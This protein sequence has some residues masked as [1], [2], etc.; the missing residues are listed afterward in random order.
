MSDKVTVDIAEDVTD[1]S[2]TEIPTS[3]TISDPTNT[4]TVEETTTTVNIAPV[5][6]TVTA[7]EQVTTVDISENLTTVGIGDASITASNL[8][9]TIQTSHDSGSWV[10]GASVQASFDNLAT[11]AD[12][13]YVNVTGDTMTGNL[14]FGDY[15]RARF[16]EGND[17]QIYHNG[18]NSLIEET[19]TGELYVR[20]SDFL[21][22]Q[23]ADNESMAK[24]NANG[25]VDL[26]FNNQNKFSTT[27]D[28]IDVTGLVTAKVGSYGTKLSYSNSNQSGILDTYGNH[29]LEFRANNDRAMNIAANGDISF[30]EDT[31][32]TPKLF[33]DASAERLGIGISDPVHTL[34][35][36]GTQRI[37]GQLMVGD[38]LDDNSI[39]SNAALHIKN[40]GLGARIRIEDKD[41]NPNSYWD[42]LVDR[43]DSFAIYEGTHERLTFKEGGNLGIGTTD[44]TEKLDVSG[45]VKATQFKGELL[46]TINTATTAATQAATDNSTKV[47]TT[48]YVKTAV[49]NLVDGSP[50]ALDTLNEL[51]SALGDDASFSTTV[52]DSIG[53]KLAKA[54][55]LSDLADAGTARTN[56][57]LGTAA[58]IDFD[59]EYASLNNKPT[60][61]S[62]SAVDTHLNQ[63]T[64]NNNEVLSWTGTDYDWVP[65]SGGISLTSI[66]VNGT[67]ATAAGDGGIAYNNSSGVFQYTPPTAA[68]IGA[69]TSVSAE[70]TRRPTSNPVFNVNSISYNAGTGV[71][72]IQTANAHGFGIDDHIRIFDTSGDMTEGDYGPIVVQHFNVMTVTANMGV[73]SDVSTVSYQRLDNTDP[74]L[75][76]S[77]S[78]GNATTVEFAGGSSTSIERTTNNKITFVNHYDDDSVD[79]YLSRDPDTLTSSTY[80]KDLLW[81]S[82]SDVQLNNVTYATSAKYT[83]QGILTQ[84]KQSG[85]SYGTGQP[86]SVNGV[87][88]S[89][90]TPHISKTGGLDIKAGG[91]ISLEADSSSGTIRLKPGTS[92]LRVERSTTALEGSTQSLAFHTTDNGIHVGNDRRG[93]YTAGDLQSNADLDY[94][95]LVGSN[96]SN[97]GSNNFGFGYNHT[98]GT[99]TTQNFAVGSVHKITYSSSDNNFMAGADNRLTSAGDMNFCGGNF[100]ETR[101]NRNFTWAEGIYDSN[102]TVYRAKN[103]GRTNCV[104]FGRQT[105]INNLSDYCMVG[106]SIEPANDYTPTKISNGYCSILWGE[107]NTAS[108]SSNDII[109]GSGTITNRTLD[110]AIFGENHLIN[111]ESSSNVLNGLTVGGQAITVKGTSDQCT[112]FGWT[113][114][115]EGAYTGA[116]GGLNNP[117]GIGAMCFGYNLK[118]PLFE[119]VGGGDYVWDNYSTVVG[120]FND[121][122]HKYITAS[123][124]STWVEDHRFVVGTGVSQASKANGFIVALPTDDFSGIIMPAL[125]A[126]NSH[127]NGADAK[128]D[129]VPVGGLYHTNGV[130]KVVLTGD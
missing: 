8:A 97:L 23:S 86:F 69:L 102:G 30:Y 98:F 7:T 115:M 128:A 113:H 75:K 39:A 90:L 99:G 54:S 110:S 95:M 35:V 37:N 91:D 55:N 108:F 15:D 42:M 18:S 76:V 92:G 78:Q 118:T 10:T 14:N 85:Q 50:A 26:Q 114:T 87:E 96:S 46:G 79:S 81:L 100:T 40:S 83:G 66:S 106:G 31:G 21:W 77:D 11:T 73:P 125:A 104:L 34:H 17:L 124:N 71:T 49:S 45:N 22:I 120:A 121:E 27:N 32:T 127:A 93:T 82:G 62:D 48:A 123:N 57:G 12:S 94:G 59:G 47:A 130:V 38:S 70:V 64:A 60:L 65:Q 61:Y 119:P 101:G 36:S 13:R 33:W 103:Y 116:I 112:A 117:I 68:G 24:F 84:K 9:S 105:E 109:V 72:T 4:I 43:G 58:T 107:G 122:A 44:P 89:E 5:V 16:G 111:I 53:T 3:V 56:L 2:V 20:S 25:S 29:N 67:E 88:F 80:D 1:V 63:S 19:G 51:A 129:G 126:S 41:G 74:L 28:G 6:N 52:T